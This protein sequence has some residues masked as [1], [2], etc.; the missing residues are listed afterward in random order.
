MPSRRLRQVATLVVFALV[1]VGAPGAQA[2]WFNELFGGS[3]A[4]PK[5]TTRDPDKL[6]EQIDV[7]TQDLM[8]LERC[9]SVVF[10]GWVAACLPSLSCLPRRTRSKGKERS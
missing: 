7:L 4:M 10:R 5:P 1:A 2:Q 6:Q 3:S 8:Q 9:E